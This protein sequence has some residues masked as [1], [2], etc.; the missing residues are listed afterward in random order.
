V[1]EHVGRLWTNGEPFLA[2]DAEI[3]SAWRGFSD[4]TYFDQVVHMGPEDTGISVGTRRGVLVGIDAALSDEGW[5]EVL[6][7]DDGSIALLYAAGATYRRILEAALAYPHDDDQR[8]ETLEVPSR[9]LSIFSS[10]L[11]GGGPHSVPFVEAQQGAMPVDEGVPTRGDDPGILISTGATRYQLKIR[12]YT[13]LD[14]DR[15]F[16]RWLFIPMI[17]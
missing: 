6:V 15:V 17:D 9:R 5:V 16:A 10:A 11:D 12:W 14:E 1:W 8:G 2:V 4:D 13:E 3:R 7:S